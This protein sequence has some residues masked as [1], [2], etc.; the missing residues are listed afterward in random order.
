[1]IVP[2]KTYQSNSDLCSLL[3]SYLSLQDESP[4]VFNETDRQARIQTDRFPLTPFWHVF[5]VSL[6]VRCLQDSVTPLACESTK[7]ITLARPSFCYRLW[8][9]FVFVTLSKNVLSCHWFP[10]I[11][12]FPKLQHLTLFSHMS[13]MSCKG[14]TVSTVAWCAVH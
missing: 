2:S 7:A 11:R 9:N 12:G 10:S 4:S 1:M 13:I 5:L 8:S 6:S 3:W 14:F